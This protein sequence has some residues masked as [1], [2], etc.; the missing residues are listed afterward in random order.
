M[1][2]TLESGIQM[3][4]L[5]VLVV[6]LMLFLTGECNAAPPEKRFLAVGISDKKVKAYCSDMNIA[7][8][9]EI[10]VTNFQNSFLE[11]KKEMQKRFPV[12]NAGGYNFPTTSM[13]PEGKH[14]VVVQGRKQNSAFK[15]TSNIFSLFKGDSH[16][17]VL[18]AARKAYKENKIEWVGV[19]RQWPEAN[20]YN[21]RK[22]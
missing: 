21:E 3:K 11:L 22:E 15:C 10:K 8:F 13:I 14:V 5:H 12:G 18:A 16:E 1:T 19:A 7:I 20:E 4:P 6:L 9:S 2:S 17:Q